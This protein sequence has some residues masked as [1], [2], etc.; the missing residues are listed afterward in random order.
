MTP[1]T[2]QLRQSIESIERSEAASSNRK[3]AVEDLDIYINQRNRPLARDGFSF[4][5]I[6]Q[7][8]LVFGGDRNKVSFNDFWFM[9]KDYLS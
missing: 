2:R 3:A 5:E 4:L 8:W 9:S 1:T 6:E 7:G